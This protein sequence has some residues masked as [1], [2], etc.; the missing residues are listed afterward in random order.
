M[1]EQN[2]E[3]EAALDAFDIDGD[4]WKAIRQA[5]SQAEQRGAAE[6]RR[7]IVAGVESLEVMHSEEDLKEGVLSIIH[8]N[9]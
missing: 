3:L 9:K 1:T 7:R 4:G 6:E 8:D 5:V 2:M